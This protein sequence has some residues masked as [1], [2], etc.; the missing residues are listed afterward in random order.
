[1]LLAFAGDSFLIAFPSP[2]AACA[3]AAAVQLALLE[4]AWPQQLLV[5]PDGAELVVRVAK[6]NNSKEQQKQSRHHHLNDQHFDAARSPCGP[7]SPLPLSTGFSRFSTIWSPKSSRLRLAPSLAALS[8]PI[9]SNSA[10]A[11]ESGCRKR[12][13]ET[14]ASP[15]PSGP[16]PHVSVRVAEVEAM[17]TAAAAA[18]AVT[19]ASGHVAVAPMLASAGGN[20]HQA[21]GAAAEPSESGT[22]GPLRQEQPLSLPPPV[23]PS[24]QPRQQQRL[25]GLLSVQLAAM[26]QPPHHYRQQQQQPPCHHHYHHQSDQ[27][28]GRLA[29]GPAPRHM[30]PYGT[31]PWSSGQVAF[32]PQRSA[33]LNASVGHRSYVAPYS[34]YNLLVPHHRKHT[35]DGF[36]C[37]N[38]PRA[39]STCTVQGAC[40]Q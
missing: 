19:D 27:A 30:S 29:S 1:M 24:P 35:R 16:H 3:Y 20:A 6:G 12:H 37:K 8:P 22:L 11:S 26:L 31:H 2:A 14:Q 17:A 23:P 40:E 7:G 10:A 25:R 9:D 34:A 38:W 5:H 21:S 39:V 28:A 4:A 36:A 32:L 15:A 13:Q 33:D 18:A